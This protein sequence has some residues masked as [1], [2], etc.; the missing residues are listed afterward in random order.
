M[1]SAALTP[2]PSRPRRRLD[3]TPYGDPREGD[4]DIVDWIENDSVRETQ[5]YVM[6]VNGKPPP[7][8]RAHAMGKRPP[9]PTLYQR[10]NGQTTLLPVR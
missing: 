7:S 10:A 8:N 2:G 5:N 6:R 4:I 1:V 3:W 9:A